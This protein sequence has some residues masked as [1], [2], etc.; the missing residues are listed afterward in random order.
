LVLD[1]LSKALGDA[2]HL[3][4]ALDDVLHLVP[5]DALPAGGHWV[6]ESGDR[7]TVSK[8]SLPERLLGDTLRI[9]VRS[10]LLDVL[11]TIP[12][13]SG[14]GTLMVLGN[15][16]YDAVRDDEKN[17]RPVATESVPTRETKRSGILRGGPCEGGFRPLPATRDEARGIAAIRKGSNGGDDT[18]VRSLEGTEA[19]RENLSALA[20]KACF[21]HIATHGWFAPDFITSTA[22]LEPIDAKMKFG[23]RNGLGEQVRGMAP[24]LLCGLAL[25]GANQPV[26][27]LGRIPGLITAQEIGALD[28]SNC[29]LAVLSACDTNVGLRRAGQGVASLQK[30]L[31]MA[32]ARSVITSL[33]KVP[34]EATKDLMIDFYRRLWVEKKPKWQALWEAKM[35]IRNAKDEAGRPTYS[36]R[37]WAAWVLTGDPN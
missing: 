36:T 24:M 23:M 32:G 11:A 26:N 15:V 19:S 4:V 10:S 8:T 33:W 7:K 28:L 2:D 18:G 30:A 27:D 16:E 34:D 29:E 25:A 12:A 6:G 9:D 22:D 35:M 37:D 17:A 14:S 13:L 1:P 3:V 5:L 31:H 20:P 21:L